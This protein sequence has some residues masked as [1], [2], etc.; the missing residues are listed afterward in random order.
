MGKQVKLNKKSD[1]PPVKPSPLAVALAVAEILLP[2]APPLPAV[3]QQNPPPRQPQLLRPL[4]NK[5]NLPTGPAYGQ[6]R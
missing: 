1:F 2:L 6:A 3:R 5:P 4:T